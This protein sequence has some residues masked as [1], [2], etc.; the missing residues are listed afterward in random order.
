MRLKALGDLSGAVGDKAKGEEFTTDKTTGS[1][2]IAR[3]I[4]VEVTDS[5]AA[6]Q[7]IAA[8]IDK[9]AKDKA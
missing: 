5:A 8:T 4:A 7:P 1:A 9:A 2:L 3:G 6:E